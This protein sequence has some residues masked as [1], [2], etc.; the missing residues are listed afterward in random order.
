MPLTT[1]AEIIEAA[2]ALSPAE[3]LQLLD[4]MWDA[5]HPEAWSALSPEWLTDVRNRSAAFDAGRTNASPW[6]D[7]QARVRRSAGLDH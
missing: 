5:E 2:R 4:A 6:Q 7:V 3:R 1:L